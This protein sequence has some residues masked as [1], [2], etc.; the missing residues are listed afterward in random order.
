MLWG[1]QLHSSQSLPLEKKKKRRKKVLNGLVFSQGVS[2]QA[3]AAFHTD[4]GT[5]NMVYRLKSYAWKLGGAGL[6]FSI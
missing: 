6:A 4:S 5:K 2:E 3:D 1:F